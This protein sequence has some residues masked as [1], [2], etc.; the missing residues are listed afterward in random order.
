[1]LRSGSVAGRRPGS[2]T[3]VTR[4][5]EEQQLVVVATVL[6]MQGE[7]EVHIPPACQQQHIVLL[8][9]LRWPVLSGQQCSQPW[10]VAIPLLLLCCCRPV[11]HTTLTRWF[12]AVRLYRPEVKKGKI[13]VA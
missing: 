3:M 13:E 9:L 12:S 4:S 11:P 5:E 10:R 2:V 1:M 7:G 8:R 6:A